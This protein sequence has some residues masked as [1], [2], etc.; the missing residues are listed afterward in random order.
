MIGSS[1]GALI[2]ARRSE[3]TTAAA[4]FHRM[5]LGPT[6]IAR[7]GASDGIVPARTADSARNS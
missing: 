3:L 1:H 7:E 2:V 4:G 5:S 6:T